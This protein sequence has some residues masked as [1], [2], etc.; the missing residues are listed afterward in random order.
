M[1]PSD[2]ENT[3]K[4][5]IHANLASFRSESL[6]ILLWICGFVSLAWFAFILFQ[7]TSTPF[8]YTGLPWLVFSLGIGISALLY[9]RSRYKWSRIWFFAALLATPLVYILV[10]PVINVFP[11]YMLALPI[12]ISGLLYSPQTP[13]YLAGMILS[14][15]VMIGFLRFFQV[16]SIQTIA[17]F[18]DYSNIFRGPAILISLV[19]FVA[20]LATRDLVSTV[21]WAMDNNRLAERRAERLRVS[22]ARVA[23]TLLELEGAYEIQTGL[24]ERLK[25]LNNELEHARA[26]AD[27][28]NNLKTRFL[29]NM[30]H[31]LRTPLNA[32]INFTQF[33]TKPRYGELTSRQL[34]LQERVLINSEHLLG[35]INDILD[36]SKIEAGRMELHLESVDLGPIFHGVMATAVGLTKSKGLTL[37]T[38]VEEDLPPVRCDKVRVRQILLNLLSNA[39]KFTDNGGITLQAFERDGMVQITIIDTGNGIPPEELPLVFE[40]FHQ[41]E[42]AASYKRQQGTGLGL[43]IS[44]HLVEL[45]GGKM[46]AESTEGVGSN[47]SFT[48]P[49][50]L[51]IHHETVIYDPKAQQTITKVPPRH[52]PAEQSV[53]SVSS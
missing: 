25:V 1:L 3:F 36:L 33:M 9:Q 14:S 10:A 39:A 15:F 32:I 8:D 11:V 37:E 30:S 41:V 2:L 51:H 48:L 42:R 16:I 5:D 19:A 43:P 46:W 13:F 24:Y 53:Q 34:E 7:L 44:R 20:W 50:S 18:D 26:A 40:E 12:M 38:D 52:Q 23:R 31:E 21:S 27:E 29:A 28:A 49:I 45:Q 22:E 4:I 35:L 17:T 6:R 47:F